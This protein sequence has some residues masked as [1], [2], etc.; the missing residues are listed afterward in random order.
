[1][2]KI[3]QPPE[4]QTSTFLD[5]TYLFFYFRFFWDEYQFFDWLSNKNKTQN[6]DIN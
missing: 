1:M 5:M 3:D 2:Y 6:K 4:E